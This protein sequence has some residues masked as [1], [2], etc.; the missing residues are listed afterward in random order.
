MICD[1]L[2]ELRISRNLTQ[3]QV[4]EG[5]GLK[6]K[7][8]STYE[9]GTREPSAMLVKQIALYYGV[10]SDYILERQDNVNGNTQKADTPHKTRALSK[11]ILV[12]NHEE[13]VILAYRSN[14]KMQPAVDKLLGIEKE[15]AKVQKNID[16]SEYT[17]NIA[18]ATG[19]EG[20]TKGKIKEVENFA[21]QV[22]E[23]ESKS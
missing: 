14:S 13:K 2:K 12:S 17:R 7:T 20:M 21:R 22:A 19:G 1:R 3:V 9:C 8:Y 10:S 23:F 15:A 16:I 18:A 6:S 5:L 4:A 11:E